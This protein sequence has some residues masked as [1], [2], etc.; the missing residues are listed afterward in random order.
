M[1]AVKITLLV[2]GLLLAMFIVGCQES[3]AYR[4]AENS[5]STVKFVPTGTGFYNPEVE[6]NVQAK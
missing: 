6:M 4:P 2:V 1:N 3:Q 5:I